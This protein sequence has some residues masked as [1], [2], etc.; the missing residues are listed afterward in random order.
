MSSTQ[1]VNTQQSRM[2]NILSN[3]PFFTPEELSQK[4]EPMK[5]YT[6][7][8]ISQRTLSVNPAWDEVRPRFEVPQ[9]FFSRPRPEHRLDKLL[10]D[11]PAHKALAA[12]LFKP[13][14]HYDNTP[15]AC[16]ID[17]GYLTMPDL[18]LYPLDPH[19]FGDTQPAPEDLTFGFTAEELMEEYMENQQPEIVATDVAVADVLQIEDDFV[20]QLVRPS[21]LVTQAVTLLR[22]LE[23]DIRMMESVR[24]MTINDALT[25]NSERVWGSKLN[26]LVNTN[27]CKLAQ[28]LHEIKRTGKTV[29]LQEALD[30]MDY[31]NAYNH[32]TQV[33]S[34]RHKN[35][36]KYGM[37]TI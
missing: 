10:I 2:A 26:A 1:H 3:L 21:C 7:K 8:P 31:S 4:A 5:I 35:H 22:L 16:N 13:A 24:T 11:S 25:Q 9:G 15:P 19:R 29:K 20:H 32:D 14:E 6:G 37:I 34:L 23:D 36:A 33:L 12:R 27:H 30:R 28:V 17:S 18:A